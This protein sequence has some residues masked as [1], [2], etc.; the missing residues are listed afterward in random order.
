MALLEQG[1]RACNVCRGSVAVLQQVQPALRQL[2]DGFCHSRV[3]ETSKIQKKKKGRRQQREEGKKKEEEDKDEEEEQEGGR[4]VTAT[5]GV[6][7]FFLGFEKSKSSFPFPFPPPRPRRS[8]PWP[9]T[10][11]RLPRRPRQASTR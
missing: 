2:G 11:N 5:T 3:A 9:L 6:D 4:K 1:K 7:N 8:Q 10:E